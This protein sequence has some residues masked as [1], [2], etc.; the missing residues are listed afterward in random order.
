[1]LGGQ[2]A[3][4]DFGGSSVLRSSFVYTYPREWTEGLRLCNCLETSGNNDDLSEE[5]FCFAVGHESRCP[6]QGTVGARRLSNL[7]R[8]P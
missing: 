7:A 1:M 4:R 3:V 8:A 2:S 6:M 5:L